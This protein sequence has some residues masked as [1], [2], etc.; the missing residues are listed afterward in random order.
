MASLH[1]IYW[2]IAVR[3]NLTSLN[4]SNSFLQFD[5]NIVLLHMYC[6]NAHLVQENCLF[7]YTTFCA[8]EYV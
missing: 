6:R 4:I 2:M 5:Y 8:Y 7:Y 1:L 3:A